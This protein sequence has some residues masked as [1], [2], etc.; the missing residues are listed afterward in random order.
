[1]KSILIALLSFAAGAVGTYL[2]ADRGGDRAPVRRTSETEPGK[3]KVAELER[4]LD[5]ARQV[6]A[7][8]RTTLEEL[9]RPV[10][11][12]PPA[13]EG[14][15]GAR[16]TGT[17]ARDPKRPRFVYAETGK[18]LEALDWS[19]TGKAMAEIMPLLSEAAAVSKG[20]KKMRPELWG[21]LVKSMGPLINVAVRLESDGVSWFHPSLIVNMIHATLLQAGQ[22]LTADQE[23]A[24]DRIGL[25]YIELDAQRIAGYGERALEMRGMLEGAK[26]HDALYSE[27]RTLLNDAQG[28]VLYP[29][30][31]R[32]IVNL[33]V[34][35]GPHI[36]MTSAIASAIARG[37]SCARRC[38]PS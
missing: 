31:V 3:V 13:S 18:T 14:E 35:S 11:E 8:L 6:N 27:V 5:E 16:G 34:F 12:E 26:L 17:T 22:P 20:E 10:R 24:L 29:P 7:K 21:D 23:Q 30:G 25:R 9:R 15:Q 2:L 1:M 28:S 19:A 4:Q 36:F 37:K 32:G 33:D 38:W